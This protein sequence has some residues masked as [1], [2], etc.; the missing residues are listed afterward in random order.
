[1]LVIRYIIA[2]VLLLLISIINNEVSAIGMHKYQ[3]VSNSSPSVETFVGREDKLDMIKKRLTEQKSARISGYG[4]IGKTQVV[5][6][7]IEVVQKSSQKYDVI[8]WVDCE[9]NI[10][11]Q[12]ND[13]LEDMCDEFTEKVCKI[14]SNVRSAFRN[15]RGITHEKKL[16]VL[17]IVDNIGSLKEIKELS[18]EVKRENDMDVIYISRVSMDDNS[19]INISTLSS[20]ESRQYIVN[21]MGQSVLPDEISK[22][23]GI[24]GGYPILMEQGLSDI[25]YN[26]DMSIKKH[27]EYQ[28][29]H[30]KDVVADRKVN[31]DFPI[32][33]DYNYNF[34]EVL[35]GNIEYLKSYN[36]NAAKLL[37]L[38]IYVAHRFD[39]NVIRVVAEDNIAYQK[40][41]VGDIKKELIKRFFI[42]MQKKTLNNE[43]EIHPLL[44]EVMYK[45]IK[46]EDVHKK[47]IETLLKAFRKLIPKE[48]T[49]IP[50]FV[51]DKKILITNIEKVLEHADRL[52][53]K[54]NDI[55]IIKTSL[56]QGYAETYFYKEAQK[57]VQEIEKDYINIPNG[58]DSEEQKKYKG[59]F[60]LMNGKIQQCLYWDR[61]KATESF[62]RSVEI[63]EYV[64]DVQL[65]H[66]SLAKLSQVYIYAGD[67]KNSKKYLVQLKKEQ[68]EFLEKFKDKYTYHLVSGRHFLEEGDYSQ[69]L[70]EFSKVEE[71]ETRI[72]GEGSS[73]LMPILLLKADLFILMKEY[74]KA[75]EVVD[76][77]FKICKENL[78]NYNIFMFRIPR[79]NADLNL[80]TGNI[81]KAES[82]IKRAVSFKGNGKN[83]YLADIYVTMGDIYIAKQDYEK[84]L[85]KYEE[86]NEIYMEQYNQKV[87]TSQ[88]SRLY[89][90]IVKAALEENT[91]A[92]ANHYYI[93]H[94]KHFGMDNTATKSLFKMIESHK[95]KQS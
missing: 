22:L 41:E 72:H 76:L 69:A 25:L 16:K 36:N 64:D 67:I 88:F 55:F 78:G 1:M 23:E 93:L 4:G 75:Q 48:I 38:L 81:E 13:L 74:D 65:R 14:K 19:D 68:N 2:S 86:A 6:K 50:F 21:I 66:L 87:E 95:L 10:D 11:I 80:A 9:N 24:Y 52:G 77:L 57:K 28:K 58:Y 49:E 82:E 45:E 32:Q 94:K 39:D 61:A 92:L 42:K 54:N 90:K 59:L 51:A 62:K 31:H 53:I 34:K 83:N 71:I 46:S 18:N 70:K 56:A 8:W 47:N 91:V 20:K 5:R 44:Q 43:Y 30:F 3:L 26:Q 29:K 17:L 85:G 84:A 89:E 60:Y 7:Y 37:E 79:I 12:V 15:I 73:R 35:R 40:Y 27:V 63:S 33:K